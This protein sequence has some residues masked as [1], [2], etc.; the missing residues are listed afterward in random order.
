MINI[1][2]KFL[3]LFLGLILLLSP[4][5]ANYTIS[6][7]RMPD[8]VYVG[9][10]FSV[11]VFV[12]NN[13]ASTNAITYRFYLINPNNEIINEQNKTVSNIP[14]NNVR[15]DVLEFVWDN[16]TGDQ[17]ALDVNASVNSYVFQVYIEPN[18]GG[19]PPANF[20]RKYFIISNPPRDIPVSDMPIILSFVF[21]IVVVF[22]F[23]YKSKKK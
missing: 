16:A 10:D 6:D 11:S 15:E 8:R 22:M 9:E 3:I 5:H 7:L 13:T 19:S 17:I 23:S 21:L 4:I 2:Y 14:A 20:S 12:S 18:E 1:N